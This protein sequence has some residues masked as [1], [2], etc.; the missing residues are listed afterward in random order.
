MLHS[1]VLTLCTCRLDWLGFRY[2]PLEILILLSVGGEVD[3]SAEIYT[4][5]PGIIAP[6]SPVD[7]FDLV[8]G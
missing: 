4:Q 3:R 8:L 1:I 7:R 5:R 2:C 6:I